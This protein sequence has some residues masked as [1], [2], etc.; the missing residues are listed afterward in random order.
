M[1]ND[2]FNSAI[3]VVPGAPVL[4]SPIYV[5]PGKTLSVGEIPVYND[6]KAAIIGY[7]QP[8]QSDFIPAA[9]PPAGAISSLTQDI[10]YS[11]VNYALSP[12]LRVSGSTPPATN[13]D[14]FQ[15]ID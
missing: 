12:K 3:P 13:L 14:P 9:V 8:R 11:N 1:A 15:L 5:L 10:L 7:K 4:D 2:L 6:N